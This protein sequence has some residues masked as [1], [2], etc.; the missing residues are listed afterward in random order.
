MKLEVVD[1]L[2]CRQDMLKIQAPFSPLE[3]GENKQSTPLVDEVKLSEEEWNNFKLRMY[4]QKKEMMY[5]LKQDVRFLIYEKAKTLA[6]EKQV[7]I[8]ACL[9]DLH[10]YLSTTLGLWV[11]SLKLVKDREFDNSKFYRTIKDPFLYQQ[12]IKQILCK[13]NRNFTISRVC[14]HLQ[15]YLSINLSFKNKELILT[16]ELL[17]DYALIHQINCS[18]PN[19]AVNF[20]RKIALGLVQ[21][22]KMNK[23]F[24]DAI[25]ISKAPE[26]V[27]DGSLLPTQHNISFHYQNRRPTLLSYPLEFID[28]CDE[29]LINQ[30]KHWRARIINR[31]FEAYP[32]NMGY[33]IAADPFHQIFYNNRIDPLPT[34]SA[35]EYVKLLEEHRRDYVLP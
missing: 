23:K 5:S 24:V 32:K 20:G 17:L 16:L 12:G 8:S 11:P 22:F 3:N 33:L 18:K 13:Y 29:P 10:I 31:D 2:K 30:I 6:E 9:Q 28:I 34:K 7:F 26:W 4:F 19:Q 27:S 35:I 15:Y 14:L 25:I 21:G 1:F